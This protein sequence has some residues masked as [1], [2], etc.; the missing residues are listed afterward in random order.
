MSAAAALEAIAGA[1]RDAQDTDRMRAELNAMQVRLD[2]LMSNPVIAEGLA[3]R[4]IRKKS[5]KA[6][7]PWTPW[8]VLNVTCA[9][10]LGWVL[11]YAVLGS[12]VHIGFDPQPVRCLPWKLFAVETH[13]PAQIVRDDLYQYYAEGIPLMPE[14]TRVVK[15]AAGVAGDSVDVDSNGIRINGKLWGPINPVVLDKAHLTLAQVTRHYVVPAGKV[16]ML[17]TLPH[18]YDGRYFGLVDTKYVSGRAFALW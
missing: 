17:G 11:F 1:R 14:G 2:K 8:F 12:F 13:A 10:F 18:T 15:Y 5:P 6:R 9:A 16:L 3:A 7:K 4:Q